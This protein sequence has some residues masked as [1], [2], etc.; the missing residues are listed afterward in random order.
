MAG[1][2][3]I[4]ASLRLI[5]CITLLV[6]LIAFALC[7]SV[8]AIAQATM[9]ALSGSVT[10]ETE[11]AV[12][13]VRLTVMNTDTGLRRQA[14]TN[15]DGYFVFPLLPAG[16]YTLTAEMP[17]FA[18]VTINDIT[19]QVSINSQIQIVLK[20]R[21]VAETINVTADDSIESNGNQVDTT[22]A[23]TKHTINNKQVS[24]L[25]VFTSDLGRNALSV[26]PFLVPGVSPTTVFG[27]GRSDT[28]RFGNQMSINGGRP[29]SVS[30]Y[31]E[32]GDNNDEGL[33]QAASPLPNP[34]ALRELATASN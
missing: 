5:L 8:P 24:S 17:G 7:V 2:K 11:A 13:D 21:P 12:S 6:F 20:P 31:L 18:A 9:A 16:N 4:A 22:T 26:L 14:V 25:P 19:L 33:D 28:N 23:T 29:S 1:Q 27:S 3:F 34:D 15:R 30:F 32:D 10:D